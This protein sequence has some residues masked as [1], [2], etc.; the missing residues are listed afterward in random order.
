LRFRF[1]EALSKFHHSSTVGILEDFARNELTQGRDASIFAPLARALGSLGQ[2]SS[3]PILED[4]YRSTKSD[5]RSKRFAARALNDL[6]PSKHVVEPDPDEEEILG[7]LRILDARL[8]QYSDWRTVEEYAKYVRDR[9]RR[10]T[11]FSPS[12]KSA[13]IEALNH[14]QTFV[15]VPVA[16]GLELLD[17]AE[18]RDAL[19]S[20]LLK[21]TAPANVR[22]ACINALAGQLGRRQVPLDRTLFR[23]L[24]LFCA[25][26]AAVVGSHLTASALTDLAVAQ[27]FVQNDWLIDAEAVEVINP[28]RPS[29]YNLTTFNVVTPESVPIK[30]DLDPMTLLTKEEQK[31]VGEG[32][33]KKYRFTSLRQTAQSELAV[34]MAETTWEIGAG[35]H[36]LLLNKPE[37][38]AQASNKRWI[39]PVPLGS[40]RIPGLAVVHC[41]VVTSDGT[42][43]LA[44][45]SDNVRYAPSRW[46]AS[47]EEQITED[48]L[49]QGSDVAA[50]AARRG[51]LEEFGIKISDLSGHMTVLSA[52]L[53]MNNLNLAIV[54]A[55]FPGVDFETIALRWSTQ[56]R[57][58]HYH[59]ATEL[60]EVD[61]QWLL[62]AQQA[63]SALPLHP[64]SQLRGR[65]LFRWLA[66]LSAKRK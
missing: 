66:E 23:Y 57:P 64:T 30:S 11:T 13:L 5:L 42:I 31:L 38:V 28:F 19:L 27:P 61:L 60:K 51:F 48:D 65:L 6:H 26:M 43:L 52:L 1:I 22:D 49:K 45:R 35:F 54:L 14:D 44:K 50:A 29:T 2:D 63:E 9:M 62:N 17:E 59:E 7:G 56:P 21:G 24:L 47:F 58:S 25:R 53:E 20:E 3:I 18:A 10:G 41:I 55:L 16:Q 33:E 40:D 37:R 36:Y 12:V 8:G 39:E 32:R 46:S 34:E 4:I 15:K